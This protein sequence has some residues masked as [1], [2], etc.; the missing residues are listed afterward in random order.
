ML[1]DVKT[2]HMIHQ[3]RQAIK[4]RR[5]CDTNQ[6]LEQATKWNRTK[7]TESWN[8]IEPRIQSNGNNKQTEPTTGSSEPK[9][10]NERPN[11]IMDKKKATNWAMEPNHGTNEPTNRSN[12]PNHGINKP[13]NRSIEPKRSS[14]YERTKSWNKTIRKTKAWNKRSNQSIQRFKSWNKEHQTR[15]ITQWTNERYWLLYR[16]TR[17]RFPL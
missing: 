7:R 12:E 2:V 17:G 11:Q 14:T 10:Q 6:I 4:S 8:K 15:S 9:P 5:K 3:Q 13:N 1:R 16:T